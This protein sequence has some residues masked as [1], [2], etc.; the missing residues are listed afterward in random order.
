ML[1]PASTPCGALTVLEDRA[2]DPDEGKCARERKGVLLRQ[3]G[4]LTSSA[5]VMSRYAL[6]VGCGVRSSPR[7]RELEE[8]MQAVAF[9]RRDAAVVAVGAETDGG[10]E[11]GEEVGWGDG[12]EGGGGE[13]AK[14]CVA[15]VDFGGPGVGVGEAEG[16]GEFLRARALWF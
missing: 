15:F 6:V 9:K 2:C 5:E 16:R 1:A 7:I 8:G 14:D 13:D 11:E 3:P 4:F 10:L 12:E